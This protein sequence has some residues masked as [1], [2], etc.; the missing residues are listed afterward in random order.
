MF[1]A[2]AADSG[3]AMQSK[4]TSQEERLQRLERLVAD[5]SPGGGAVQ[6]QCALISTELRFGC[7]YLLRDKGGH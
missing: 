4:L 5:L 3:Q 2:A 7:V 6:Q 1:F